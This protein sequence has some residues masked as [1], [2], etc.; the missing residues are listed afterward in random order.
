MPRL[1]LARLPLAR[2]FRVSSSTRPRLTHAA[3]ASALPR[4]RTVAAQQRAQTALQAR[5]AELAAEDARL[6][7][8]AALLQQAEARLDAI[9]ADAT[10]VLERAR[11][12]KPGRPHRTL[13]QVH[14]H[15]LSDV[16]GDRPHPVCAD[17]SG[18]WDGGGVRPQGQLHGWTAAVLGRPRPARAAPAAG[19][20]RGSHPRV[21]PLPNLPCRT[22]PWS[23]PARDPIPRS[24]PR[25]TLGPR[26]LE[27]A[28]DRAPRSDPVPRSD[29][30]RSNPLRTGPHARTPFHTWT[31]LLA[32]TPFYPRTRS[33]PCSALWT[34]GPAHAHTHA[35]T[36]CSCPFAPV[37]R[38][39]PESVASDSTPAASSAAAPPPTTAPPPSAP[40]A[41]TDEQRRALLNLD[42][43]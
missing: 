38:S 32:R 21:P 36:P 3:P 14:A 34:P 41:L 29:P 40:P 16:T 5:A 19:A 10:A 8:I 42:L 24:D 1:P 31:P 15:M 25:S 37:S 9:L 13:V 11:A 12:A 33:G 39:V 43:F 35:L 4:P 2:P 27:P 28:P 20:N 6:L 26:T 17:R 18:C 30:A 23:V 7:R 22:R